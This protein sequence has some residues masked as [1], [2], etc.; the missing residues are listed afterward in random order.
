MRQ[1]SSP[2]AMRQVAMSMMIVT[3]WMVHSVYGACRVRLEVDPATSL[4]NFT[5]SNALERIGSGIPLTAPLTVSPAL[6]KGFQPGPVFAVFGGPVSCPATQDAWV[7]SILSPASAFNL[8]SDVPFFDTSIT[9]FPA[10]LPGLTAGFP[11]NISNLAM[12]MV[13]RSVPGSTP[14]WASP[15]PPPP[16][17]A[18]P[19][20]PLQRPAGRGCCAWTC[21]ACA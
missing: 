3:L 21:P 17:C 4:L 15:P 6:T 1:G 7:S 18:S 5:G 10:L 8:T 11:Y 20:Q 2:G 9:V 14:W 12:R 19:C 16:P 13:T